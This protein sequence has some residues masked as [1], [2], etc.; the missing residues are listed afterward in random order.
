M[1]AMA[2][3]LLDRNKQYALSAPDECW[4]KFVWECDTDHE[5][6]HWHWIAYRRKPGYTYQ[7]QGMW[8]E[9]EVFQR[10]TE[11]AHQLNDDDRMDLWNWVHKGGLEQFLAT[12]HV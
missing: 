1:K 12:N 9:L 7:R 10:L 6:A 4:W 11:F 2:A 8:T 5:G 3:P